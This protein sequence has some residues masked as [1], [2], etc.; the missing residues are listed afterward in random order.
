[1]RRVAL[2]FLAHPDGAEFRRRGTRRRLGASGW[3]LHV[4][5]ATR[6][7]GGSM[8]L[9]ADQLSAIRTREAE[10]AAAMIGAA[11]HCLGELDGR[12][13]YDRATTQKA[14]DLFRRV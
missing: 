9:A 13:C 1:M 14:F 11:Y 6:G 8:T 5:T 10:S 2:A 12:V 3:D 4:A 7:D